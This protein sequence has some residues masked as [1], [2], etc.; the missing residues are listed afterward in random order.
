[1]QSWITIIVY[2]SVKTK[3]MHA[4][5][6]SNS[7]DLI[8]FMNS[9]PNHVPSRN[10]SKMS[11]KTNSN[12]KQ[13]KKAE[14]L[15]SQSTLIRQN[16][17]CLKI[18]RIHTWP[19]LLKFPNRTSSR[20]NLTR[21]SLKERIVEIFLPIIY[22]GRIRDSKLGEAQARQWSNQEILHRWQT[23]QCWLKTRLKLWWLDL[24]IWQR[25]CWLKKPN[26]SRHSNSMVCLN[27]SKRFRQIAFCRIGNEWQVQRRIMHR[28]H[29]R[30]MLHRV[31]DKAQK[32]SK[33]IKRLDK[34]LNTRLW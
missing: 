26:R 2:Q 9:R 21:F 1:M 5:D 25:A 11:F 13:R 16:L 19:Y 20:K 14:R 12:H 33:H 30:Q 7:H 22:S 6:Q 27:F 34:E 29:L 3:A 32:S 15:S 18:W 23:L 31:W 4:M 24:G 17:R 8:N 28:L 10:R